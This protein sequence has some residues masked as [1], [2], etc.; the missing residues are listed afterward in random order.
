MIPERVGLEGRPRREELVD[1][2]AH[3]PD[4]AA[5]VDVLGP[6]ICSGDMKYGDHQLV[7]VF[8][9]AAGLAG[10]V[11]L[12][13]AG[14]RH[15]D[16]Q[17]AVGRRVKRLAGFRSRWTMPVRLGDGVRLD[18]VLGDVGEGGQWL[19]DELVQVVLRCSVDV[20][21]A[22]LR[23]ADVHDPG[24]VLAL[25]LHREAR[26]AE[27]AAGDLRVLHRLR[28]HELERHPLLE[29]HVRGL[30]D[31]PHAPHAEDTIDTV[32][33]GEDVAGIHRGVAHGGA[34]PGSPRPRV[35]SEPGGLTSTPSGGDEQASTPVLDATSRRTRCVRRSRAVARSGR[36]LHPP[37]AAY[38]RPHGHLARTLPP[39]CLAR[40]L[41]RRPLA[42]LFPLL[43]AS[44]TIAGACGS[45]KPVSSTAATSSST[46]TSSSK[47]TVAASGS[48]GGGR[49]GDGRRRQCGHA[50]RRLWK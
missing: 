39:R 2:D 9:S 34:I 24:D 46:G 33:T 29:L 37:R 7:D 12:G 21:R 4:V 27:E 44:A 23:G 19:L 50:V 26:L 45:T 3:G 18:D 6:I 40:C 14:G 31:D 42:L 17:G 1:D 43:V 8:V 30:D 38:Y 49:R 48:D 11:G 25:E 32:F 16:E 15:L 41:P 22:R 28:E 10:G 47:A 5:G 35:S 36:M 20:R 13:D